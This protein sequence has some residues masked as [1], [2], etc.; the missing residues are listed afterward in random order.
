M[1][2]RLWCSPETGP[3]NRLRRCVDADKELNPMALCDSSSFLGMVNLNPNELKDGDCESP[4]IQGW[5]FRMR[6]LMVF[7][8]ER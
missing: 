2:H 7:N 4:W 3:A 6:V 8:D 1:I 5:G